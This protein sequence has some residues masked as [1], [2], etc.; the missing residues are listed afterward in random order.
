MLCL[1]E[2]KSLKVLVVEDEKSIAE[3]LKSAIGDYFARFEIANDGDEG[4]LKCKT[5]MPD[6]IIY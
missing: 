5:M 3:L 4:V 1:E 2:L 6:F